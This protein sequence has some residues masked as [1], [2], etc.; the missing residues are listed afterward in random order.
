MANN[1]EKIQNLLSSKTILEDQVNTYLDQLK[2]RYEWTQT[3]RSAFFAARRSINDVAN[4]LKRIS[5]KELKK[6]TSF[7]TL[8]TR[9]RSEAT[10]LNQKYEEIQGITER[11]LDELA[12]LSAND[13]TVDY[14]DTMNA[15]IT[16]QI[17]EF[18][19]R[20]L[21]NLLEKRN[22]IA[23]ANQEYID[24]LQSISVNLKQVT[25]EYMKGFK[26]FF[27][28][29]N[30]EQLRSVI[31]PISNELAAM[32]LGE[33]ASKLNDALMSLDLKSEPLRPNP[34]ELVDILHET[35]SPAMYIS[36]GYTVL[37]F[38]R[39][40]Y[41]SMNY[42]QRSLREGREYVGTKNSWDK[43][44]SALNSLEKYYYT[45]YVQAG[46]KPKNYHGHRA[47]EHD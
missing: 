25:Q 42:F 4:D 23:P 43:Y 41:K 30:S 31:S 47:G 8:V 33:E 32:N 5:K 39:P 6:D 10:R 44:I 11:G 16:N 28:D 18:S 1:N 35:R 36:R 21:I 34:E 38:V 27:E 7:E 12:S 13:L 15:Y 19:T 22:N 29:D 40:V 2:E 24:R 17:T 9:I 37:E 26:K 45:H 46:G 14:A 3:I 20:R